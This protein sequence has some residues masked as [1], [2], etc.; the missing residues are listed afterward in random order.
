MGSFSSIILCLKFHNEF[1]LLWE[2]KILHKVKSCFHYINK[3][4][5]LFYNKHSRITLDIHIKIQLIFTGKVRCN[6]S[7]S[8]SVR[9]LSFLYLKSVSICSDVN[10]IIWFKGLWFNYNNVSIE[11]ANKAKI[12]WKWLALWVFN[13]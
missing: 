6:T 3:G 1:I 11:Y 12:P 13:K 7:V 4:W 10:M 9:Y 8:A 5:K 2:E